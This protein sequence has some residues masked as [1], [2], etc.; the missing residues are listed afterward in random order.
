MAAMHLNSDARTLAAAQALAPELSDRALEAERLGTLPRDLVEKARDAH[1]FGLTTPNALGGLE[2]GP[3]AIVA[4]VEELC[5]ADGSAGWTIMIGTATGLFAWFDPEIGTQLLDGMCDPITA[6]SFAPMGT[7]SDRGDGTFVFGGRWPFVSGC[8][9]AD[10]FL[11]GGFVMDGDHP[12][13]IDGVG[14]DWRLA[15]VPVDEVEIID[16][17]DVAGLRG[18]GSNDV[19]VSHVIVDERHTVA[20]FGHP[21]RHPTTLARFPFFT[22][23]GMKLAGV[24][25]GIGRRALDELIAMASCKGRA[26]SLTPIGDDADMQLAIAQAD[27]ELRAARAFVL[28]ALDEAYDT[29]VCGDVPTME[30]RG[31]IQVAAQNAMR[32]GITAVDLAFAAGGASALRNDNV[33]QRCFRDLHAASQ[34]V[35]FSPSAWKRYTKVLLGTGHAEHQML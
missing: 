13:V 5:R 1:L 30:Q 25:L 12:R 19:A 6:A 20:P 16:N 10:R 9:H 23:I 21:S 4:T 11:L 33:L 35:Y 31:R 27:A 26:G 8:R 28:E 14:P 15:H 18:T 24:P 29:A 17:W 34:H 32:A 7:L 2:L 22:L 3:R